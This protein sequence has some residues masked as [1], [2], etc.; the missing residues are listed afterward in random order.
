MKRKGF[1]LIELLSVIVILGIL[2]AIVIP[3]IINVI[4]TAKQNA[5]ISTNKMI[6]NEIGRINSLEVVPQVY[7]FENGVMT[8]DLGITGKLPTSGTIEI[9]VNK[10]IQI[11]TKDEDFCAIKRFNEGEIKSYDKDSP[12]C[13]LTQ[14]ITLTIDP[15]GGEYNGSTGDIT[16]EILPDGKLI[17]DT[18]VKDDNI[19]AGWDVTCDSCLVDDIY[20][21]G[22]SSDTIAAT[23]ELYENSYTYTGTSTLVE[24]TPGYWKLKLLTSGTFTPLVDMEIDAFMVGGGGGGYSDNYVNFDMYG[25]GGGYTKTYRV[26]K[27][28]ANTA[29]TVTIGSGGSAAFNATPSAGGTTSAFGYTAAGGNRGGLLA[30][31]VGNGG[32]A[33]GRHNSAAGSDGSKAAG[34]DSLTHGLGQDT[35]T[36]EFEEP[37]G[38]LYSGGGANGYGAAGG[39]GGGGASG[40][41]GT[42]NT[43]GGGGSNSSNRQPAAGGS[44][45]VV[46]RKAA[47]VTCVGDTLNYCFKYSGKFTVTDGTTENW[48]VKLLTTGSFIPYTTGDIDAFLVGGGGGGMFNWTE[49]FDSVGGGGGYTTNVQQKS[50]TAKTNYSV[51]IGNGGAIKKITQADTGESTT[52]FG[53]TA[54][55]GIGGGCQVGGSGGSGGGYRT[56]NGGSDG[57]N[58]INSNGVYGIGQGITTREFGSAT[59]DLYAGG[60][61]GGYLTASTLGGAG[62]GGNKG[63]PG[64]PNTGGG[65]GSNSD[66]YLSGKGGSGIVVIR[67]AVLTCVGSTSQ[68]CFRYSGNYSIEDQTTDNW[69]IKFLYSGTLMS[70]ANSTIDAFL[71]GGGGGGGSGAGGGG[72]G[73]YTYTKTDIA[74]ATST[75]YTITI[76]NGGLKGTSDGNGSNGVTTS[77]FTYTAAGGY[78]GNGW[79]G[80]PRDKGGNGGSGAGGGSNGAVG[81]N[82]GNDGANGSAGTTGTYGTGQGTTTREFGEPTGTLYGSGGGGGNLGTGSNGAGTGGNYG[83]ATNATANTGGGGGGSGSNSAYNGGNGGSGIVI[84]RAS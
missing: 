18:P 50:L 78:G 3:R 4:S 28:T 37:T 80:S 7:T 16:Y 49:C 83:A 69:K 63:T 76:G 55:G 6:E 73:G 81:G 75:N 52:A 48:K 34:S 68:Y 72:G 46:I 59:G 10:E 43:G 84:I 70:F 35:T 57:S 36:R 26:I 5:F 1:T 62:G 71:V 31:G 60:G 27:L 58:G 67:K 20:T 77:A 51:V 64:T 38:T 65:G 24:E 47:P 23:W 40:V 9:N 14:E 30:S 61:G 42:P 33:G 39:A 44:G 17:L 2:L 74:L 12:D 11:V 79:N 82:G 56:G 53:Y 54:A 8:P 19:F 45:I 15:N 29:Y 13:N 25:G 21:V 32:S 41:A 22:N 66:N